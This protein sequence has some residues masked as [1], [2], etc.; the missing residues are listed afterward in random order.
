MGKKQ[1]SGG[2]GVQLKFALLT[3]L[4]L[5]MCVASSPLAQCSTN[6]DMHE[7]HVVRGIRQEAGDDLVPAGLRALLRDKPKRLYEVTMGAFTIK[8]KTRESAQS[9]FEDLAAIRSRIGRQFARWLLR[10][11]GCRRQRPPHP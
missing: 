3:V 9:L 10:V 11:R 7:R 8:A 1:A 2:I 5:L 4:V 6:S